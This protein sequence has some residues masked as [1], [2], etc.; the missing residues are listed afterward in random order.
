MAE[1]GA[2]CSRCGLPSAVFT[3]CA[4]VITARGPISRPTPAVGRAGD[5]TASRTTAGSYPSAGRAASGRVGATSHAIVTLRFTSAVPFARMIPVSPPSF[6]PNSTVRWSGAAAANF[7]FTARSTG[8]SCSNDCDNER[9][10]RAAAAP[11]SGDAS[12]TPP[13]MSWRSTS[14]RTTAPSEPTGTCISTA[15]TRCPQSR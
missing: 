9:A 10:A 2:D 12:T 4:H 13:G 1:S 5:Q 6:T 11:G 7:S 8:S 15:A 3:T 14:T